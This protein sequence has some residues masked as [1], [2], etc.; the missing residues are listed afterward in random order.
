MLNWRVVQTKTLHSGK[1]LPIIVRCHAFEMS[2]AAEGREGSPVLVDCRKPAVR[3]G[4][5]GA[6]AR[7]VSG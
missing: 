5:H 1:F 2:S 3:R 7:S 6:T 4:T